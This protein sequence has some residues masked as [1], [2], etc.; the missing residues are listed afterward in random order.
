MHHCCRQYLHL[1][2]SVSLELIKDI[3]MVTTESQDT[4][5]MH[6]DGVAQS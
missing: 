3:Q 4:A 1:Q 2:V 5:I 6:K